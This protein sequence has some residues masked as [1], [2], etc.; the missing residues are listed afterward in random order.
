MRA[1]NPLRIWVLCHKPF[2]GREYLTVIWKDYVPRDLADLYEVIDH[3]HAAAILAN[4]FIDEF[5]DICQA[6]SQFRFSLADITVGGGNES[7]IPK[8]FRRILQP[9]GWKEVPLRAEMVVDGETV[10]QDTHKV[11]CLKGRVACDIEW[12]SKDQTFDRDLY[13]FRSFYE[14]DRISVGVLVTRSSGLNPLFS[15]LGIIKKYG[16]STTHMN[17]L[18]PRLQ[19]GRSGGCPLLVFGITEKLLEG[20]K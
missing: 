8:R 4:E 17:K 20:E 6:L 19:A 11:D 12:N 15:K 1:L 3:R 16:A 7:E 9:L 18:I 10:R 5:R 14:F 2:K 13:A